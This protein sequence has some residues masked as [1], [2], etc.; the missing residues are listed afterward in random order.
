MYLPTGGRPSISSRPATTFGSFGVQPNEKVEHIGIN[1]EYKILE[2]P[3]EPMGELSG[4][5]EEVK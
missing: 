2:T 3:K 5:L 4:S 1:Y